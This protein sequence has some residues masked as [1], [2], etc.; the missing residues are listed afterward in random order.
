MQRSNDRVQ[1]WPLVIAIVLMLGLTSCS[2]LV[3]N[4][5]GA[6][7]Q[8]A[9]PLP[10]PRAI[11]TP[12]AQAT[13]SS[14]PLEPT[15]VLPPVE[16]TTA[17]AQ[18]PLNADQTPATVTALANLNLRTN[19]DL[20]AAIVGTL[21][22]GRSAELRGRSADG[23]W[24]LV[25]DPS[26]GVSVWVT[27]DP[28][29]SAAAGADDVPIVAAPV[30]DAGS[31]LDMVQEVQAGSTVMAFSPDNA[32]LALGTTDNQV[33]VYD[34]TTWSLL[35][36]GAH[37]DVITELKFS[38]NGERLVSGSFDGKVK[39]WEA[40]SGTL[41]YEIPYDYWVEGVDFSADGF[42]LASGSLTGK[43]TVVKAD[44]GESVS[45]TVNQLPITD[46]AI[47]PD[48]PW[49]AVMTQGS[50]GPVEAAVWDFRTYERRTLASFD[51]LPNGSNIVFDPA[52]RW[53]AAAVTYGGPVY[54][55]ETGTWGE[56][57][58]IP[59][60]DRHVIQLA[61]SPDGARL[62]GLTSQNEPAASILIWN[63]DDWALARTIDLD[64]IPLAMVVSPD[65]QW[66]ATG[67]GQYNPPA[68]PAYQGRIWEIASGD[69]LARMPHTG[70][71][72]GLAF[73]SDSR[74][75]ATGSIDGTSVV[76]STP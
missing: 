46:L 67:H 42:Y 22:S 33:Q 25:T 13:T 50:W 8:P 48:G 14:R 27:A 61:F 40:A 7:G 55:W 1:I 17:I 73:S 37:A 5:A 57:A 3:E 54:V 9:T 76:W 47:A 49:L 12:Q 59:V 21:E 51:G 41:S 44:N 72:Q 36:T 63:T 39:A 2:P 19:P 20:N 10:T 11:G 58:Q 16:S 74:W 29:L 23:G 6:T 53:L 56:A 30:A 52:T 65:S 24:W 45:E 34:T 70:Q 35:W 32:L 68:V 64:E 62:I 4:Q 66:I 75:V 38:P 71:V 26:D 69:L 31:V 18:Q 43:G 60:P 15:P 28:T